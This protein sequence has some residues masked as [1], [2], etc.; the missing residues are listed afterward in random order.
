MFALVKSRFKTDCTDNQKD[1]WYYVSGKRC[2]AGKV[3]STFATGEFQVVYP[4]LGDEE[5]PQVFFEALSVKIPM[6][7]QFFNISFR[8]LF[9]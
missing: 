9:F 7:Y 4:D 2:E 3:Q 6:G 1:L 8:S 5:N